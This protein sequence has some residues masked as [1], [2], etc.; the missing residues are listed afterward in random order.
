M[1]DLSEP[2]TYWNVNAKR[3]VAGFVCIYYIVKMYNI[4]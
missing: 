1:L 4:K 3:I 2:N